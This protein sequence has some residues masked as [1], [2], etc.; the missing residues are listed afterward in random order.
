MTAY[1]ERLDEGRFRATNAVQGA[2]N[3]TE[4]HIAPALGL[5]VHAV[6][7]DRDRRRDA[8]LQ[9]G[10]LSWDILG[11]LPIDVVEVTVR[12]LRAG[13]TIELVEA[14][15][16][17]EGRDAVVLRCWLLVPG[18]TTALAGTDLAPIPGPETMTV[19]DPVE[20]WPGEFVQSVEVRRERLAPGR[21]RYWVRAPLPLVAGEPVGPVAAAAGLFDIANGMVVRADPRTVA[22]PN[23]DLTTHLFRAP[24]PGWVGFD[25][26]VSFGPTG[27]GVTSSVLHDDPP[28]EVLI[29]VSTTD[30]IATEYG[31]VH[32]AGAIGGFRRATATRDR[33]SDGS[34][35]D[36][37]CEPGG[38]TTS[39]R[40]GSARHRVR[41]PLLRSGARAERRGLV[42][43]R[44]GLPQ[45]PRHTACPR[46]PVERPDAG[47]PRLRVSP[48]GVALRR[49]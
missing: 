40:G 4:Q 41:H 12:V 27:L 29:D 21:G 37:G 15:L 11:V 13:R 9:I 10:R 22:F 1:F 39:R 18:E 7:L 44:H 20:D 5:L 8:G 43:R 3:V 38:R 6:E 30:G 49:R 36:R 46:L 48:D 35:R 32:G 25:T 42:S 17:H 34:A 16:A 24:R 45:R 26:S 19:W 28:P 14:R 31:A 23:L 47:H 2:W 33:D